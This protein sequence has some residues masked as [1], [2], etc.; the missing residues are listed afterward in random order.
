[1]FEPQTHMDSGNW[2]TEKFKEK[3]QWTEDKLCL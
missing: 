2:G 3:E 1:M